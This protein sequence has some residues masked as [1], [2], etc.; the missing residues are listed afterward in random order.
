MSRTE[1][2]I[3][4]AGLAADAHGLPGWPYHAG[5]LMQHMAQDKKAEAGRLTFILA[6]SIGEAFV[7]KDVDVERVREFLASEGAS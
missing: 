3:A 2:A 4:A 5:R 1:R 7:A 6:R